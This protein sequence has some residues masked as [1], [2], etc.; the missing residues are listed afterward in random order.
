M[1][2][3]I[4][5]GNEDVAAACYGNRTR[6]SWTK[7]GHAERCWTAMEPRQEASCDDHAR[8]VPKDSWVE[9]TDPVDARTLFE[10]DLAV[11]VLHELEADP[12]LCFARRDDIVANRGAGN[13]HVD[14]GSSTSE[15]ACSS[16][17]STC[18]SLR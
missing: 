10:H 3:A 7:A 12:V 6:S 16:I 13:Q 1:Y 8:R 5:Q 9:A 14:P 2:R 11:G 15:L 4:L 17:R 18:L